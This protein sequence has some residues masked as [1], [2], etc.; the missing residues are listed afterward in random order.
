[1]K[2]ARAIAALVVPAALFAATPALAAPT[3]LAPVN[4]SSRGE[5]DVFPAV[6]SSPDGE[7]I[8]AWTAEEAMGSVVRVATRAP[9]G[10]WG[11]PVT[12]SAPG[13]EAERVSATI[14]AAGEATVTWVA[15]TGGGVVPVVSVEAASLVPGGV[16]EAPRRIGAAGEE[17]AEPP[18]LA[19][20]AAGDVT[21]A[22]ARHDGSGWTVETASRPI[23]G[24]WA[25]PTPLSS[26]GEEALEPEVAVNARGDAVAVWENGTEH[27]TVKSV[28]RPAGGN[29][30]G[31]STVTGSGE[32]G[33]TPE[34]GLDAAGDATV[35]WVRDIA[36]A[37]NWTIGEADRPAGGGWSAPRQISPKGMGASAPAIAVDPRGDATAAW[38]LEPSFGE[39]T[40][41]Q[42]ADRTGAGTWGEPTVISPSEEFLGM[43]QVGIDAAG[44]ATV[45]WSV[46]NGGEDRTVE[47]AMHAATA[48]GWSVPVALST[49][50]GY[51]AETQLAVD[52]EGDALVVWEYAVVGGTERQIRSAAYDA[53]GP[54]MGSLSIPA[55]G[56]A[57]QP[58]LFS[59]APLDAISPVAAT[60]WS[61][62]DGSTATT[63]ATTHTYASP[64]TYTVTVTAVDSSGNSSTASGRLTVAAAKPPAQ[65]AP[66]RKPRL[67]VSCP[68]SAK[69]GGC[70]FALQIV[71]GKPR[72]VKGK[73]G[74]T[75][76]VAPRPE[77]A[78]ARIKL[79][80]GR[81]GILT[82]APKAKFAT[83][84]DA[85]RVL[86][87]R[88]S[89]TIGG[90]SKT[91]YR[92]LKVIGG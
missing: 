29:W 67:R 55:A 7:A 18:V 87:V 65:P 54:V 26:A 36:I 66:P 15:D 32:E 71:A 12:I 16:W 5:V 6:A 91:A 38:A 52:P 31:P 57:G 63:A 51:N 79:A 2:I 23:G 24:N 81:S 77:S 90:A 37:T 53:V 83:R 62:G 80:A 44:D 10:P 82:L 86:L 58:L 14:D 34:V 13:S 50:G 85:A 47:T 89:T 27:P 59:V 30:S 48:S 9:G 42:V 8:A 21:V 69:P 68:K 49:P 45:V 74:R 64:G 84:L 88:K 73:G 28:Q 56:T 22:W 92:R 17:E 70:R 20:D 46:G 19:A 11:A 25:P 39:S 78:V 40:V 3:W 33:G 41:V 75:H 4:V 61:F 76:M 72:R 60:T 43:P 35:I 1:M